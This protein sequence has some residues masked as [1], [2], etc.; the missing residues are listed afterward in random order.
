MP[1]P[2]HECLSDIPSTQAQCAELLCT[3]TPLA[4]IHE[5]VG[6]PAALPEAQ[7]AAL[8]DMS[9][10][11][12]GDALLLRCR[13]PRG[14]GPRP[15]QKAS[16]RGPPAQPSTPANV[17]AARLPSLAPS[18]LGVAVSSPMQPGVTLS[19]EYPWLFRPVRGALRRRCLHSKS[20]GA[21]SPK[22]PRRR[23]QAAASSDCRMV[24]QMHNHHQ[25]HDTS[26]DARVG[27]PWAPGW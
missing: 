18:A 1:G 12:A 4:Y 6:P 2:Q 13:A 9:E 14:P 11:H 27:P 5:G 3:G 20:P 15:Q 19:N 10:E 24:Q 7:H 23:P 21:A 25:P 16:A 26:D 8:P 22:G 17:G